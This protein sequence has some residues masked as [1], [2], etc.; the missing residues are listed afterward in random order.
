MPLVGTWPRSY[1]SQVR[2][3]YGGNA[4]AQRV[5]RLVA[6]AVGDAPLGGTAALV[7]L[8]QAR[9]HGQALIAT[10]AAQLLLHGNAYLQILRDA[11]G[12]AAELFA[13]RPERV[14][15]ETDA[16]GW[17]AAYRYKVGERVT[18]LSADPIRPDV[19]HIRA[20]HP[21]DDHYGLGC[22]RIRPWIR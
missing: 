19:I 2:D 16:G 3:A 9:T 1:E 10:A 7:A 8:A 11:E 6:E 17:P 14:S 4:V 15:V 18:R 21:T 22:L 12:G 20:F 5:V 13:L